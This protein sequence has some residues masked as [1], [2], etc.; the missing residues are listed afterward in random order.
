MI[1]IIREHK[2]M[3][4]KIPILANLLLFSNIAFSSC[5]I[6]E[7]VDLYDSDF[8]ASEIRSE[9]DKKVEDSDCSIG[10]II[11]YA[12][13][14]VRLTSILRRCEAQ[15]NYSNSNYGREQ[16]QQ[17]TNTIANFCT[18]PYGN[19]RMAEPIPQGASCY[20]PTYNGPVGG[21]AR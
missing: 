13:G 17:P 18:T 16:Y 10:K 14:G 6:E 12:E 21:I 19:C 15:D 4:L 20:C 7:V 2:G 3:K 5:F 11:R 8:S 9:C 1:I